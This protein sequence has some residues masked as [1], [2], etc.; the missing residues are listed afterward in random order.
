[1]ALYAST[2][3]SQ[4]P[5]PAPWNSP[6]NSIANLVNKEDYQSRHNVALFQRENLNVIAA[7][8]TNLA[9]LKTQNVSE[10]EMALLLKRIDSVADAYDGHELSM[11]DNTFYELM[12]SI[13]AFGRKKTALSESSRSNNAISAICYNQPLGGLSAINYSLKLPNADVSD[14]KTIC[15][16]S[17]KNKQDVPL[18]QKNN[19]SVKTGYYL[20]TTP[21]EFLAVLAALRISIDYDFVIDGN[22]FKIADLVEDA[23]QYDIDGDMSYLLTGL[24]YYCQKISWKTKGGRVI[25]VENI[26][27]HEL[28]RIKNLETSEMTDCLYGIACARD[29]YSAS[30][31]HSP[32]AYKAAKLYLD[33]YI[34]MAF[35]NQTS[36]YGWSED[37]FH[38]KKDV[39]DFDATVNMLSWLVVAIPQDFLKE[40]TFA[41]SIEYLV[42]ELEKNEKSIAL[43]QNSLNQTKSLFRALRVIKLYKQRV[44]NN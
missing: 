34:E 12:M 36:N 42:L 11:N 44:L 33:Y 32:K 28:Y 18:S 27:R 1:M 9:S 39:T 8:K 16:L 14:N 15:H 25:Q 17:D 19:V 26:L 35:K 30:F 10:N 38:K 29:F 20:Q 13:Y 4:Q 23:K 41:G 40:K 31:S 22:H 21:G 37:Y 43:E 2:A 7:H 3:V 6:N 24:S 5:I